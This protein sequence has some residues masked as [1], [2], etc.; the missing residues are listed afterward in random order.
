VIPRTAITTSA[1]F[2]AST[3]SALS[4]PQPLAGGAGAGLVGRSRSRGLEGDVEPTPA[5][6]R[7]IGDVDR[8][9]L[10]PDNLH[11]NES[12]VDESWGHSGAAHVGCCTSE[13]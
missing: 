5:A 2:A 7:P 9:H 10:R 11:A 6:G 12:Q 13:R 4:C 3:A 1:F 8:F